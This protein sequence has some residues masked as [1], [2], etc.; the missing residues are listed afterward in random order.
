MFRLFLLC[1][2]LLSACQPPADPCAQLT[3][4][5]GNPTD[6]PP[7]ADL[8]LLGVLPADHH[9]EYTVHYSATQSAV[10]IWYF[11]DDDLHFCGPYIS[12]ITR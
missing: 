11:Y 8:L 10:W 2:L 7:P 1:I 4:E 3:A 5:W 12:P 6:Q 9:G